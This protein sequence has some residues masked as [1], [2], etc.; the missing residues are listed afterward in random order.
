M[1]RPLAG[2]GQR[3]GDQ[4]S[5]LRPDAGAG[6][7]RHSAPA[8]VG[9]QPLEAALPRE[10]RDHHGCQMGGVDDDRIGRARDRDDPGPGPQRRARRKPRRAGLMRRAGQD[11]R[12]A[13]GVFVRPGA[14]AAAALRAT[15]AGPLTKALGP[16][17]ARTPARNADVDEPDRAASDRPGSSRWPGF[18]RK[19]VTLASPRPR[20]RG[21]SG[22]AVEPRGRVH[23]D[24]APPRARSVDP[25]D[26]PSLRRRGRALS[27]APKSAS[28]TQSAP[29]RATVR[30]GA[31]S[32]G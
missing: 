28:I 29:S 30:G 25:L 20:R 6:A 8:R 11:E 5:R 17:R 32:P 26:T 16:I 10:R 14:R 3:G 15:G 13:A 24:T 4:L 27:P 2:P 23:R 1:V 12:R 9:E 31:A 7:E 22:R 21:P 18:S 19:K